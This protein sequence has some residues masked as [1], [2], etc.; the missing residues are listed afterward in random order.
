MME[1]RDG[2]KMAYVDKVAYG[3]GGNSI[4]Q[5]SASNPKKWFIGN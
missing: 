1:R 3:N 5:K 2:E 4:G